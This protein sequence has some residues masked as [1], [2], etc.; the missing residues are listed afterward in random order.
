MYRR[1]GSFEAYA[2]AAA[3]LDDFWFF[4]R[5]LVDG[6]GDDSVAFAVDFVEGVGDFVVSGFYLGQIF[7]KINEAFVVGN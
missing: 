4:E 3:L 5:E 2:E 1:S 7:E 6:G